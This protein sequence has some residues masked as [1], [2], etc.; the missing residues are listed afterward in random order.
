VS[1]DEPVYQLSPEANHEFSA[2]TLRYTFE[3]FITPLSVLDLD[4][5]TDE[6]TLLKQMPVLGG[7]DPT[8]YIQERV[9]AKA[10]DGTSIPVSVVRA[11][12]VPIDGSAAMLL[13]AYGSYEISM[14]VRFS[15]SRL[16]LLDRG[17]VYALAHV[18]GGGEM[19][20]SWYT[21]GK[22]AYKTNTFT[23]LV[24]AA[25]SLTNSGFCAPGR[26]AIRGASAGGLTVGAAVNIAPQSFSAVVAEV[27]FVDVVNT[28]LDASLPLTVVEWEE[29]GNPAIE[30]QYGW[31]QSYAPYENVT[32]S[33]YPPLLATAGLNDP[34]VS[35]WEPA[36]WVQ[37]LRDRSTSPNEVL[38]K[39][40]MVA[41]HFARSGRYDTW[42]DEALVLAFVLTRL[43]VE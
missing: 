23:D 29:W 38:L 5:E 36:K 13:Y 22:F 6:R 16:S 33:D 34:R 11:A 43:G 41:G 20:K 19:G 35:F 9:W 3:S 7:Y 40:E 32:M 27:P 39:T 4:L 1:F 18:R 8:A 30:S 12:K 31:I 17:V 28:M 24:D 2:T 14:P 15:I 42:K 37:R 10:R 21:D 25:D 26:I